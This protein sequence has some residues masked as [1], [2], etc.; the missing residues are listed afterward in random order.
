MPAAAMLDLRHVAECSKAQVWGRPS[1]QLQDS[2][3]QGSEEQLDAS[4]Q[5]T[6]AGQA[7][8]IN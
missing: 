1:M 5:R 4:T 8:L 7:A 6:D 3:G 2:G